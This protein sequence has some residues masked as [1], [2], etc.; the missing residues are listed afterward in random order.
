M[1]CDRPLYFY[2]NRIGDFAPKLKPSR[3]NELEI[4]DINRRYLE[5]GE[6]QVVKLGRG[7]AWLDI[8]IHDSLI[9]ASGFVRTVANIE[10]WLRDYND[11]CP[12]NSLV[13]SPPC[14]GLMR[15]G[16]HGRTIQKGCT[17]QSLV[18]AAQFATA[19]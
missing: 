15:S 5:L 6:L 16:R 1:G 17:D 3:R 19:I 18:E 7:Y 8:G 13:S 9:E 14:V 2:D 11:G 12:H 10:A 4:T